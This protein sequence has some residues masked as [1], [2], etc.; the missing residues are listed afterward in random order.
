MKKLFIILIFPFLQSGQF[1]VQLGGKMAGFKTITGTKYQGDTSL[2]VTSTITLVSNVTFDFGGGQYVGTG[3][4]FVSAG[5]AMNDSVMNLSSS[6]ADQIFSGAGSSVYNGTATSALWYNTYAKNI[7]ISGKTMFYNGVWAGPRTLQN[8]CIGMY[9]DSVTI[10][11]DS[12]I[13]GSGNQ[14]VW[15]NS[16]YAFTANHWRITGT[17]PQHL[18]DNGVIQVESGN[19]KMLN[20][21]RNGAMDGYV[22]RN[23]GLANLAGLTFNQDQV[24]YNGV[25]ASTITYG[26]ADMQMD[27]SRFITSGPITSSGEDVWFCHNNSC[28][29]KDLNVNAAGTGGYVTNACIVGNLFGYT[30]H[31]DSCIA[32]GAQVRSDGMAANSS[33]V[34]DN[35][36]G[37]TI[38]SQ[39]GNID[40]A[41]G[42]TVPA[43][44][45]DQN[46]YSLIAGIGAKAPI[47][48]TRILVDH[49]TWDGTTW[50]YIFQDGFI[51]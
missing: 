17:T 45:V 35:S 6:T 13:A 29:K 28:N 47:T 4:A 24:F 37:K 33:L 2:K 19:Y 48:N 46:Y 9:A 12:T 43:G 40:I 20:Y 23:L 27:T 34:K 3:S 16:I 41:P 21:Y 1:V 36:S 42:L 11:N 50:H 51:Q 15:G 5:G 7:T 22:G 38:I 14:K 10:I 8:V 26:T 25:D 44:I 32:F 49:A 31:I 39:K 30:F 18:T